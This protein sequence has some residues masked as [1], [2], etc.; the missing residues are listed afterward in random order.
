MKTNSEQQILP[1]SLPMF[2]WNLGTTLSV[3]RKVN[4]N[5]AGSSNYILRNLRK[6]IKLSASGDKFSTYA[7]TSEFDCYM[8]YSPHVKEIINVKIFPHS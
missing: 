7:K 6:L 1:Q 2:L 3:P 5:M 8:V 4:K